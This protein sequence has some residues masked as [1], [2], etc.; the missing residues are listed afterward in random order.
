MNELSDKAILKELGLRIARYRL[1]KNMTQKMLAVEAGVSTPT[2][3]RAEHGASIQVMK[4]IRIVR[5]L[6]LIGNMESLVPEP[7]V[8]PIQQLKM[9]RKIRQRAFPRQKGSKKKWSWGQTQ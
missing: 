4:L 6:N 5:A 9:T 8:S 7:P 2:I 1:N 3:Q